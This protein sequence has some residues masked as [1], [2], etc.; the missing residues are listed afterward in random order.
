V[1]FARPRAIPAVSP[2]TLG[3]LFCIVAAASL[4][5]A[6]YIASQ[7]INQDTPG[8]SIAFYEGIFGISFVLM[9]R[10]RSLTRRGQLQRA[11]LPWLILA[12]CCNALGIGG[13]Y[14]ALSHA[15]LSVAAPI[16]GI[17]PLVSY[18]FVLLLLRGEEH[19]TRRVLLG[20]GLVVFGVVL[21]GVTSG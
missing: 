19:V 9:L 3:V 17:T 14:T 20:A 15:P 11:A 5:S 1:R 7:I 4:A 10:A 16:T 12:G 2:V 21:V 6:G 18:V 13:F 8:T